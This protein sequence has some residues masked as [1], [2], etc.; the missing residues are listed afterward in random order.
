M[1]EKEVNAVMEEATMNGVTFSDETTPTKLGPVIYS[2]VMVDGM[3][4]TGSPVT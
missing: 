3:N 2:K 4:N 1:K